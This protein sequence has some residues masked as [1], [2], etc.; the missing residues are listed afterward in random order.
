MG[1]PA[2][3]PESA[4]VSV[5]VVGGGWAGLACALRLAYA[6]YKPVVF[7]S[8][9]EVG[10]RARRALIAGHYRDN[11]QHLM[12]AGCAALNQ[13]FDLAGIDLPITPFM[14]QSGGRQ[15]H[16]PT[17]G[18]RLTLAMA[19]LRAKGFSWHERYRLLVALLR[20]QANGW[21]VAKD[22]TVSQ[23]LEETR[24]P[25]ALI[26][27]F[28]APLSLAVLNTPLQQASIRR[29]MPVLR[30]TLGMGGSALGIYQP[31]TNLSDAI[32]EP[33][34]QAIE[35]R[36]G[37]VC[38]GER[39][40]AVLRTDTGTGYT[41]V[42]HDNLSQ[43]FDHV[44]LALPPWSLTHVSL[45][46]PLDAA[47]SATEFGDQPIA[48][49]YL[50]FKESYRL[51]VPLLQI[52]G[53]TSGDAQIWAIDRVHCGEPGVIAVSLSAE[54]PWCTLKGDVLADACLSA[55]QQAVATTPDCLWRKSVIVQK[56]TYAATI[57]ASSKQLE[58]E[59]LPQLHLAGDWTHAEYPATLEAAVDSGFRTAQRI[60]QQ[61]T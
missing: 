51:P 43:T 3:A 31:A 21:R 34:V 58:L 18:G 17:N 54:G 60:L 49:V 35:Q 50:G 52:A 7:E 2:A 55:L 25:A 8:A 27:A 1:K 22:Y 47:A 12:L 4:I 41:I 42:T 10:G 33:L 24:Q 19:L 48:T 40:T 56:A 57:R 32:I 16:V 46:A 9:P 36:G 37:A 20:L 6:G 29:L 5:A 28:W 14:Y 61:Q 15:L 11:G 38:C 44:V 45:P 23:W 13:L 59:P 53:P 39:V 26:D 30:D